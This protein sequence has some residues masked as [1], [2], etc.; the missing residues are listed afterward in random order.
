MTE[1]QTLTAHG[2]V[3]YETRVCSSCGSE[4]PLQDSEVFVIGKYV[5]D[6]TWSYRSEHEFTFKHRTVTW[7]W[8]CEHCRDHDPVMYP[9]S[10]SFWKRLK[11]LVW[12]ET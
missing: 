1:N 4:H 12:G 3:E 11:W 2:E 6:D 10:D 5:D 7:G 9:Q 8:A